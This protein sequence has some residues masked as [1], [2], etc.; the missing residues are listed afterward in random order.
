MRRLTVCASAAIIGFGIVAGCNGDVGLVNGGGTGATGN[1]SGGAPGTGGTGDSGTGGAGGT[2]GSSTSFNL[3]GNPKYYRVIKLTNAQWANAVQQVLNLPSPT[4]LEQG[5]STPATSSGS[6]SNNELGLGLDGRNWD[7]F[8]TAANTIAAQVT[9]TDAALAKVYSGTD[10]AGLITTLGRRFYRRP[11]TTA[12]QSTYMT[13]FSSG[14]TLTG[15]RSAFAKGASLVIRAMLQSPNFLFRTELAPKGTPL[16]AYEMAAKIS[17][18]LRNAPP[19]DATLDAAAGSGKF[20]TADGAAALATKMLSDPAATSVMRQFHGEWLGFS[21][22]ASLTRGIA[23]Y[24]PALNAE[25]AESSYRFF[26]NIFS[27][28]LGVKD[29]FLSSTAFYGPAMA[30]LYAGVKAP[31]AGTYGQTDLGAQRPGWFAQVPF[32]TLNGMDDHNEPASILRGVPLNLNVVCAQLGPP[33]P[34]IPPIPP[35]KPGETNRQ[36]IDMLT[37]TCGMTC[38]NDMIN[39]LGFAFERFDSMGQPR[40]T[41]NGLTIDSTGKYTFADGT[42]KTWQDAAGLMQVLASTPQVHT[43]YAKKLASYSLQRDVVATDMPMLQSLTT[44]SVGQGGS[45]K[46]LIVNLVKSD[47]FRTHGGP[48]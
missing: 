45:V 16:N 1:S 43:C 4:G 34:N 10:A 36:N 3:D 31:A 28:G 12:E 42:T 11:L 7:D 14:S 13:L 33:A 18:M 17:L 22:F 40:D 29:I 20:D 15:S 30:K 47:A 9:A 8:R 37:G 27:Q 41:D 19:D 44:V 24:T 21:D 38:H 35:L 32:L 25:F 46:Q 39:P 23:S 2:T 5:F 48:Q 6:F 26:D